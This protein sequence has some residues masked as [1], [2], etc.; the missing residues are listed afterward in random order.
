LASDKNSLPALFD[1][2]IGMNAVRE[3]HAYS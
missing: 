3:G 1:G 2:R